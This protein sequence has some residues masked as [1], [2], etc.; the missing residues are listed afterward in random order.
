MIAPTNRKL[1][2]EISVDSRTPTPP[3]VYIFRVIERVYI[4]VNVLRVYTR[5]Y[6]RE[7]IAAL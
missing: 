3:H 6:M 7:Y 5:F 4:R 2:L 1:L